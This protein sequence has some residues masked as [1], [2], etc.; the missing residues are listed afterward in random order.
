[1]DMWW[2]KPSRQLFLKNNV[3]AHYEAGYFLSRRFYF[4]H[5]V[6]EI[7]TNCLRFPLAH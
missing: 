4:S 1:M 5:I 3:F 6:F 7:T 2:Y